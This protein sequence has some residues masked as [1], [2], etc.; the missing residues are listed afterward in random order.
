[1]NFICVDRD[2]PDDNLS[3][4]PS[5]KRQRLLDDSEFWFRRVLPARQTGCLDDRSN[6]NQPRRQGKLARLPSLLVVVMRLSDMPELRLVSG[7]VVRDD[8]AIGAGAARR[9]RRNPGAPVF[10]RGW[11]SAFHRRHLARRHPGGTAVQEYF[12][13]KTHRSSSVRTSSYYGINNQSKKIRV[14]GLHYLIENANAD[15]RLLIVDDVFRLRS[16]RRRADQGDFPAN[17]P[18]DIRVA[19]PWYKPRRT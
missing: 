13:F 19:C 8:L 4:F 18:A 14:H 3:T 5:E 15:D 9:L 17:T 10:I 2:S 12:E 1:M 7:A 16:Q 11:F 6:E